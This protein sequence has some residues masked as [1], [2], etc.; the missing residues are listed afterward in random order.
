MNRPPISFRFTDKEY[1]LLEKEQQEG[2]SI[3]QTAS[4]LLRERLGILTVD[5]VYTLESTTLN[6]WISDSIN[7]QLKNTH[8]ALESIASNEISK[9]HQR[10]DEIEK[11]LPKP[12]TKKAM[13]AQSE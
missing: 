8:W 9:I 13:P 6:N 4:R 11:R 7:S 12:R 1:E 10:L 5:N 3:N 2:E